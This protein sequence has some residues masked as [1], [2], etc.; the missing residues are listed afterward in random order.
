MPRIWKKEVLLFATG[1]VSMTVYAQ[2]NPPEGR[3][4]SVGDYTYP[5]P[6]GVTRVIVKGCGGGG[7]GGGGSNGGYSQGDGGGAGAPII[8]TCFGTNAWTMILR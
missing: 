5:V 1:V 6:K 8:E 2:S 7:G 3:Y 4:L